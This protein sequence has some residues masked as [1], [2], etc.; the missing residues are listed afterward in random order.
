MPEIN[1]YQPPATDVE[2]SGE[3]DAYR[4]L[5]YLMVKSGYVAPKICYFTGRAVEDDGKP[6]KVLM[7]L[8]LKLPYYIYLMAIILSM[9]LVQ[10]DEYPDWVAYLGVAGIAIT[11]R[12]YCAYSPKFYI[13]CEKKLRRIYRVKNVIGNILSA[14]GL[15]LL[16]T[17]DA[18]NEMSHFMISLVMIVGSI[19]LLKRPVKCSSKVGEYGQC[20]GAHPKFLE[21]L[22]FKD[23]NFEELF[24]D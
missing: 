3:L 11:G 12:I 16:L 20:V 4:D 21:S 15:A 1:P 7:P 5:Q 23:K 8:Q 24:L 6:L 9:T 22:P 14:C 10:W 17:S 19:P 13:Y 18:D 2:V